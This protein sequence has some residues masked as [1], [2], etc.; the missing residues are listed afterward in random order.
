MVSK[1]GVN[2]DHEPRRTSMIVLKTTNRKSESLASIFFA[3]MT[4]SCRWGLFLLDSVSRDFTVWNDTESLIHD[5]HQGFAL[6]KPTNRREFT[7]SIPWTLFISPLPK[8]HE[9]LIYER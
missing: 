6:I 3:P 9:T 4:D 5:E 2:P 1:L 8:R 7:D